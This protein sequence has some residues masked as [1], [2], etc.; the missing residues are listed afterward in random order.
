MSL[1]FSLVIG[2][3]LSLLII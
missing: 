2:Y 1:P 3:L